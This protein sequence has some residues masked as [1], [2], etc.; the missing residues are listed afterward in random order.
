M[1]KY[2]CL[3]LNVVVI[4]V[5]DYFSVKINIF[6]LPLRR[7][8]GWRCCVF[9]LFIFSLLVCLYVRSSLT[10]LTQYYL[11]RHIFTKLSASL[12]VRTWMNASV[13][14]VKRSRSQKAQQVE[15]YRARRNVLSS[16]FRLLYFIFGQNVACEVCRASEK[17][18]MNCVVCCWTETWN[19]V[20]CQCTFSYS[21]YGCTRLQFYLNRTWPDLHPQVQL[22]PGPITALTTSYMIIIFL[23]PQSNNLNVQ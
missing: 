11:E 6:L 10:L 20:K 23:W 7:R 22:E 12:H 15:T 2:V 18:A 13:F 5:Y 16:N 3:K 14:G 4:W 1:Y 17:S 8:S 19:K 9:W 21:E